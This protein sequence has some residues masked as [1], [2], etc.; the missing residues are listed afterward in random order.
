MSFTKKE[1]SKLDDLNESIKNVE[2]GLKERLDAMSREELKAY[3]GKVALDELLNQET[4]KNDQ[5]LTDKKEAVKAASA[6]YK[7][8]TKANKTRIEY[9][10]SI[11]DGQ[12]G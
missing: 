11:L 12:G 1:Q 4:K 10:K 7:E 6:G 5:D 8:A 9:A 2:E 3:V